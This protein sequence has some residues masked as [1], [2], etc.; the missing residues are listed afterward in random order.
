LAALCRRAYLESPSSS[1]ELDEEP[2]AEGF[3]L[4][5]WLEE[6]DL[7][8]DLTA[9]ERRL[10]DA[11]VGTLSQE[12]TTA[13]TWNAEALVALGWAGGLLPTLAD[14]IG[15]GDPRPVLGSVPA[16][17]D[18]PQAWIV[19]LELRT[20]EEIAGERERAEVWLWRA[21]IEGERRHL[22]GRRLA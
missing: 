4:V 7:E 15:A 3:D 2:E 12:E 20:E 10:L 21:E 8:R 1:A 13:A 16:P 22:T 11:P 6:H 5:T 17:W 18:S 19:S 14:P 9:D